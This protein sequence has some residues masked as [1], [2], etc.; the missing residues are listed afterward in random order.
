M[1]SNESPIVELQ[2]LNRDDF[3][4]PVSRWSS[5]GSWLLLGTF[6]GAMG[7]ASF[8][9]YTPTVKA[10]AVA[11]PGG[12]VQFIP[13]ETEGVVEQVAVLENQPVEQGEAIAYID[14]SLLESQKQGLEAQQKEVQ[15][16][17][18]QV[19]QYVKT[20]DQQILTSLKSKRSASA[21]KK[22]QPLSMEQAVIELTKSAPTVAQ[23]LA[24]E[25][26]TLLKQQWDLEKQKTQVQQ[27]LQQI[28]AQM[29]RMVIRAP[30]DGIITK[31]V[32]PNPGQKVEPDQVAAHIVPSDSPLIFKALVKAE[33]ISQVRVD[34]PVLIRV[35]AYPFPDYG[36][37]NGKVSQISFSRATL[38]EAEGSPDQAYYEVIIQPN[39]PYLVKHDQQFMIYSGMEGR[40]DI[41]ASPETVLTLIL[42]RA[43]LISDL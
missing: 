22:L 10:P 14:S 16:E 9:Q 27:Q 30:I 1:P 24:Q 38:A 43:R 15:Q 25:R 36:T 5:W 6:A 26:R 12:R 18:N 17:L 7:L 40:A 2:P 39:Q 3:L 41:V 32:V 29:E 31:V 19:S 21:W 23:P 37:L 4:P 35:S 42:R 8:I 28:D 34:Q 20:L 33:D 13:T 11:Q